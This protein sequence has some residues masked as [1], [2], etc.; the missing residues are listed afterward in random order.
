MGGGDLG[1]SSLYA[2]DLISAGRKGRAMYG[3]L[4]QQ[5]VRAAPW[6]PRGGGA[7]AAGAEHPRGRGG[8]A[9]AGRWSQPLTCRHRGTGAS[10]AADKPSLLPS[11]PRRKTP[12]KHKMQIYY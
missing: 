6:C 3:S 2:P 12:G 1:Q 8:M 11:H 7:G 10:S 9:A 5:A 4:G